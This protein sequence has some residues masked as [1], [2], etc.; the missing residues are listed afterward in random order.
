MCSGRA[1]ITILPL[2]RLQLQ[3]ALPPNP[4]QGALPP[5]PSPGALPPGPPRFPC[6]PNDLPW[7]RPWA[8][9]LYV[10]RVAWQYCE[11]REVIYTF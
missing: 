6:P 1:S 3:G 7:R 10:S 9:G 2:K 8:H 4:Y 11:V 5:G